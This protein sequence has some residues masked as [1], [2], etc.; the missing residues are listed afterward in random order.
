MD[1]PRLGYRLYQSRRVHF[2]AF[3]IIGVILA[4]SYV[5]IHKEKWPSYWHGISPTAEK[6]F[7]VFN[8]RLD[9][10]GE[11]L[12]LCRGNTPI[13]DVTN[14]DSIPFGLE[15]M[16]S[17]QGVLAD[18]KNLADSANTIY[19]VHKQRFLA[20]FYR[21]QES[22]RT[23]MS[24][25]GVTNSLDELSISLDNFRTLENANGEMFIQKRTSILNGIVV[26]SPPELN[27]P[28]ANQSGLSRVEEIK[29]TVLNVSSSRP[30][31][32]GVKEPGRGRTSKERNAMTAS[33]ADLYHQLHN[34]LSNSGPDDDAAPLATYDLLTV[35]RH[36]NKQMSVRLLET[37]KVETR[38]FWLIGHY[39]WYEIICWVWFGV[40]THSIIG[41]G[42]LLVA[43]DRK[44]IWHPSESYR[45]LAKLVYAPVLVI[46][47]FFLASLLN[48]EAAALAF[49]RNSWA[50]LGIAFTLGMFPN[51]VY[52]LLRQFLFTLFR[53]E[54]TQT[55]RESGQLKTV[56]VKIN[57]VHKQ[58]DEVYS[59][60]ALK[61]NLFEITTA[62]IKG[63]RENS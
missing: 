28:K 19:K 48:V 8:I 6:A 16:A 59:L 60:D 56:A 24:T 53:N 38:P 36:A 17:I 30:D 1:K 45:V 61:E 13:E 10:D 34:V 47:M 12:V 39:R 9:P 4:V 23:V 11:Y 29:Q 35:L 55:K 3:I 31:Q 18:Q 42:T 25:Q 52:R 51:T 50:T 20:A 58:P 49:G 7:S 21:S 57:A 44:K 43:H 37:V 14:M 2:V 33:F 22:M 40:M 32:L 62:P 63:G 15:Q 5:F 26:V 46:V 41:L 27:I 54:L